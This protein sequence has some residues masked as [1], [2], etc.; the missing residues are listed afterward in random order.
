MALFKPKYVTHY[1]PLFDNSTDEKGRLLDRRD[2]VEE[3]G[4]TFR[5][6]GIVLL[7]SEGYG[8]T[9][10]IRNF[11]FSGGCVANRSVSDQILVIK[12]PTGQEFRFRYVVRERNWFRLVV[13]ERA[14]SRLSLAPHTVREDFFDY[15]PVIG[16]VVAA[17]RVA[18]ATIRY[19]VSWGLSLGL[20]GGLL[21][22]TAF[23]VGHFYG[24]LGDETTLK[25]A[26]LLWLL[27]GGVIGFWYLANL[28]W[29]KGGRFFRQILP[30]L[31]VVLFIAAAHQRFPSREVFLGTLA[32]FGQPRSSSEVPLR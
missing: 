25:L 32:A 13:V 11:Q 30:I 18:W 4:V 29:E 19:L 10:P 7:G 24:H 2:E 12:S 9:R 15:G 28:A 3:G 23:T 26:E 27:E 6:D 22:G 14:P 17:F 20:I 16:L 21:Y 5:R 31:F 8:F 1:L